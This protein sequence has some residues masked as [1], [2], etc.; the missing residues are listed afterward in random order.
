VEVSGPKHFHT[1]SSMQSC[2]QTVKQTADTFYN[3][4]WTE[5]SSLCFVHT[6]SY[7][8]YEMSTRDILPRAVQVHRLS[9][10]L[11]QLYQHTVI[12]QQYSGGTT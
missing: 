3:Y 1:S 5:T 8:N 4:S 11:C 7:R 9:F 2:R 6:M 10:M 12:N